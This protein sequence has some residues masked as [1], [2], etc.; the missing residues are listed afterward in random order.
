MEANLSLVE[1]LQFFHLIPRRIIPGSVQN[2]A[3]LMEGCILIK[4]KAT[5]SID[6]L[7]INIKKN[8]KNLL[9]Q[10]GK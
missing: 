7:Y 9:R 10:C 2:Y 3:V 1:L 8:Q 5:L 6:S 4:M